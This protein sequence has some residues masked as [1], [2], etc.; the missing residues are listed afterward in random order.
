MMTCDPV[1]V[2]SNRRLMVRR[3]LPR[4]L[5]TEFNWSNLSRIWNFIFTNF[6]EWAKNKSIV[7]L[8]QSVASGLS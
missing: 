7:F 8:F 3:I 1:N 6:L 2:S 4:N 5:I